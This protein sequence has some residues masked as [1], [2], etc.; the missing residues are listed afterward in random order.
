MKNTREKLIGILGGLGPMP[1]IDI[2]KKIIQ[3][4]KAG[5]DQDHLKT[6][7]FS[8]PKIPNRSDFLDNKGRSPVPYI[9]NDLKKLESFGA[10]FL[11]IACATSHAFMPE[12]KKQIKKPI[13]NIVDETVH[14]I[15][16]KFKPQK[17]GILSSN[18]S[19]K[20]ELYKKPLVKAKFKVID[21]P[22][23]LQKKYINKA[24]ADIKANRMED[25]RKKILKALDFFVL[26]KVNLVILGC[27]EIPLVFDSKRNKGMIIIDLNKIIAL[28]I[29]KKVKN[30]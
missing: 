1:T 14:Y 10:D 24:I 27:T 30:G 11:I 16:R 29:I 3:N 20:M 19:V 17:I 2:Q 8:D 9:I 15:Q 18:G 23:L 22:P 26:H 28:S 5:K 12:I 4:T 21:L 7:V 25:A 13:I 6:V